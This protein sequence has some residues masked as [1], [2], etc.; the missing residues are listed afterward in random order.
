MAELQDSCPHGSALSLSQIKVNLPCCALFDADGQWYRAQVLGKEGDNIRVRYV[1]YGNEEV[2]SINNLRVPNGEQLTVLRPQALECCLNGYQNMEDDTERDGILEELILEKEFVMKVVEMQGNRALVDLIDNSRYNVG[3]LL[4][5]RIATARSQ[6]SPLL[7]QDSHHIE[8]R[9]RKSPTSNK[10]VQQRMDYKSARDQNEDK[11]WNHQDSKDNNNKQDSWRQSKPPRNDQKGGGD[12]FDRTKG[13]KDGFKKNNWNENNNNFKKDNWNTNSDGFKKDNWNTDNEGF[14][15]DN[16]NKNNEGFKKDKWN[17]DNEGF[18]KDNWGNSD[19]MKKGGWNTNNQSK[20][21]RGEKSPNQSRDGSEKGN[22]SDGSEKNWRRSPRPN[23]EERSKN[24][25]DFNKKKGTSFGNSSSFTRR[26]NP[27]A[28]MK[29]TD[30][31]PNNAE[32]TYPQIGNEFREV[33]VSWFHDP[34]NFFCQLVET[35]EDF[36]TM[37]NDIQTHYLNIK[38]DHASSGAPVIAVYPDD[39]IMYRGRVLEVKGLD[40]R[41]QY[42]DFGNVCITNKVWPIENKFMTLPAQAIHCGLNGIVH[43]GD[44]WPVPDIFSTYF[45]KES[46]TCSFVENQNQKY[47]VELTCDGQNISETLVSAG[48][49]AYTM[50]NTED[51]DPS[52]LLGQQIRAVI[53]EVEGLDAF[54]VQLQNGLTLLSTLHN[55]EF[56]T[57]KH[58]D[59]LNSCVGIDV[60]IYVDNVLN[61]KTEI[62]LYD[63]TGTKLKIIEPDEGAYDTIDALCPLPVLRSCITG[64]ISYFTPVEDEKYRIFLQPSEFAEVLARLLEN[65]F[66]YYHGSE[67]ESFT[68]EIGKVY[69]VHS[70]DGNWYRGQVESVE[71]ENVKV[72]YV[73]YGNSEEVSISE[74]RNL[75]PKFLMQHILAL[76]VSASKIDASYIEQE[77]T[78]NVWYGEV[79]WV[80]EIQKIGQPAEVEQLET[81]ETSIPAQTDHPETDVIS[82]SEVP[83]LHKVGVPVILSHIDSPSEFYIQLSEDVVNINNLQMTLQEQVSNFAILENPAA[84]VLCA[85]PYSIDQ[86][87]YR[88]QVL[89]ADADITTVRFV[90][91]GNTDVLTN[92][93]TEVKTLPS[94]LLSLEQHARRCSLIVKAADAEWSLS[95]CERFESLTRTENLLAKIIHQD[96]KTTFIELYADGQNV[97]EVL[98]NEN[99][100]VK[101]QLEVQS[102]C[103]GYVSHLNSPSEFWIQLENSVAD[104]EWIAEQ[105]STAENFPELEDCTPGSLCAALFPDDEMWYRARIL[106]NTIAGLEVLFIDYGNSCTCTGLR[107]LPEDLIMLPALAQKCSLQKPQ[108]MLQWSANATEE[109]KNVSADGATVFN[110]VKFSTGETSL[111]KLLLDGVDISSKLISQTEDAYI[112]SFESVSDFWLQKVNDEDK[113]NNMN[114]KLELASEWPKYEY[115]EGNPIVAAFYSTDNKWYRARV[116]SEKDSMYEVLFIDFGKACTANDIHVLPDDIE[117]E[118]P[119]AIQC[120]L[121]PLPGFRWNEET[122][123]QLAKLYNDGTTLFQVEFVSSNT[124]RLYVNGNDI[125][126]DL[127]MISISSTHTT[128]KK[129]SLMKSD[130]KEDI[131]DDDSEIYISSDSCG[132]T[133]FTDSKS[134]INLEGDQICN[135]VSDSVN[136]QSSED[137]NLSIKKDLLDK[138]EGNDIMEILPV[139]VEDSVIPSKSENSVESTVEKLVDNE[140]EKLVEG[141]ECD[142]SESTID[143]LVDVK[144]N[145]VDN[146]ADTR[147]KDAEE[148]FSIKETA[149]NNLE[150]KDILKHVENNSHLEDVSSE[151]IDSSVVLGEQETSKSN[152]SAESLVEK[153]VDGIDNI[154]CQETK[155]TEN[156][157]SPNDKL[158]IV[159]EDHLDNEIEFKETEEIIEDL[160]CDESKSAVDILVSVNDHHLG[161]DESKEN[162]EIIEDLESDKSKSV[163]DELVDVK[164]GHLDKEFKFKETQEIIDLECGESKSAVDKLTDVEEDHLYNKD[165]SKENEETIE[166]LEYD[167]RKSVVDELVDVK[168]GHSDNEVEFKDTQEIIDLECGENK[169]AVDKLTDVEEHHLYNEDEFKEN[170]EL[171]EDLEYNESKSVV[172]KLIDIKEDYLDK[173]VKFRETEELIEDLECDESKLTVHKLVDIKEENE[174]TETQEMIEDLECD[175]SKVAVDKLMNVKEDYLHKEVQFKETE[176]VIEDLEC[177][178]NRLTTDKFED[179]KEDYLDKKIDTKAKKTEEYSINQET[180]SSLKG[181][182]KQNGTVETNSKSVDINEAVSEAIDSSTELDDYKPVQDKEPNAENESECDGTPDN[183]NSD[184]SFSFITTQRRSSTPH[185]DKIVPGSICHGEQLDSEDTKSKFEDNV[186]NQGSKTEVLNDYKQETERDVALDNVAS[187]ISFVTFTTHHR[188]S[189]P[190]CEKIVPGSICRGE[191][192]TDDEEQYKDIE[193][194]NSE[195]DSKSITT[196]VLSDHNKQDA[197][198]TKVVPV[199][200]ENNIENQKLSD[201]SNDCINNKEKLSVQN[202]DECLKAAAVSSSKLDERIVPGAIS[203]GDSPELEK[204]SDATTMDIVN[205]AENNMLS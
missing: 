26:D 104:L 22:W 62:T 31:A 73:D 167:E 21:K 144:D 41:V 29:V 186:N 200:A 158:V 55:L 13:R 61:E 102:S 100:A 24:K 54:Y 70:S 114:A 2:V 49:A 163:V 123:N 156:V 94:D 172:D 69:A 146:E 92:A 199:E 87:W 170:E 34:T 45:A 121:E 204:I 107:Q 120:K 14:K 203:R 50:L 7:I 137:S 179:V 101:L 111:V 132:N 82:H 81:Q 39:G 89:D 129:S 46:I 164:E 6:V 177:Y 64:W 188:S 30:P 15:K 52:I 139:K 153:L 166:D 10:G 20:W 23:N 133:D 134:S 119:L 67:I 84:G 195:D 189:I 40:Y 128:P 175:E 161:D 130:I 48:L 162:E 157:K 135:N 60:I 118:A 183:T 174:T 83:E 88:A 76:E 35:R 165:E 66:S 117:N 79:G 141:L 192:L 5:E 72:I 63:T 74:L 194:E 32:Y 173:E 11:G 196:V 18:K 149:V 143:K 180:V 178:E 68:T 138:A 122:S 33:V 112:T 53:T 151:V 4:L 97:A 182:D 80:A 115:K 191:Q 202:K 201:S 27:P 59:V 86:Q 198:K 37:M 85:A 106:S 160:E 99:L 109:F 58:E 71:S 17:A 140:T 47:L 155:Q 136:V 96:E 125:R 113:I 148:P 181:E 42:V 110:I 16:W 95:A 142:E 147:L 1:D 36:R 77:V 197:Y 103:S 171:I 154:E 56:A 187:N 193:N 150:C 176:E 65:L 185:C 90:D 25:F 127:D 38:P 98:L 168:E 91:Y 124:V 190:H 28:N 105:L 44:A 205:G 93:T 169:S 108:G 78:A 131:K 145:S 19:D 3:S 152:D 159:Q 57:E 116:L 75:T 8:Q 9:K 126:A 43:L 12:N 51:F 184:T